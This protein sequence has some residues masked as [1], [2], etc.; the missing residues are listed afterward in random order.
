MNEPGLNQFIASVLR[1]PA[2]QRRLWSTTTPDA[3]LALVRELGARR[4]PH[5]TAEDLNAAMHAS[6]REWRETGPLTTGEVALDEWFPI[7]LGWRGA[8]ATIEWCYMGERRFTEP[9]FEQTVAACL[10]HPFNRLFRL[11]TPIGRLAELARTQPGVPP[12]GLI[13]H[14]SR[15]GSTL[16]AQLLAT[17]PRAIML[18]EAEPI[19]AA[20]RARFHDPTLTDD[21]RRDWLRWVVGALGRR[22]GAQERYLFVKF[23]SWSVLD[24]PLIRRAFPGVPWVFVYRDPI[25]VMVSHQKMRGAQMVPGMLEPALLSLDP[26]EIPPYALDEYCARVLARICA[27]AAQFG[28]NGGGRFV[29][30]RQLPDAVW[31]SLLDLFGVAYT[32]ADVERMRHT[33]LFSAKSPATAFTG[34]TAAKQ[35]AASADLRRLADQWVRPAYQQ[36]VALQQARGAETS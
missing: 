14:M 11:Q 30:Y 32:P 16:V 2:A 26:A 6:R 24:L 21:Q 15:C 19:D 35:R 9:F 28:Q 4:G 8:Q 12:T 7:R 23:D 36:L 33:A 22:R 27:A 25:E 34:D 5:F 17:L 13:F 3:F 31:S 18:A 20:L 1:E 10:R 29:D